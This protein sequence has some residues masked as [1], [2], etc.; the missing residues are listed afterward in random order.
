MIF[1]VDCG[2]NVDCKFKNL[3]EFVVMSNI[4]LRKV[5][6]FENFKVVLVNV[7]LEEGKGNDLVKRLYE[8][9]KKL[10]LNF[11]GNVEVREVINVYIDIIICDGFIG[12]ILFKFVEG[13]VFLVMSFIKEIFMVSIKSK[14]GVLFIKDDL[15]KLKS[16]IDYFEYGGVLFLGLNGGVIKVYGSFDVKVIKNVIN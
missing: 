15:R 6:G 13:V 5:L 7:G 16:F 3:V 14:I 9:I 12:N 8:E 10:D 1:I 2:V 4:Y 11:I